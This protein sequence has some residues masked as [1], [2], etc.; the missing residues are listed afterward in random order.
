MAPE[1]D[2]LN[3]ESLVDAIARREQWGNLERERFRRVRTNI[4]AAASVKEAFVIPSPGRNL[5]LDRVVA[6]GSHPRWESVGQPDP[7]P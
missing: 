7:D 3:N 2:S 1:P 6:E 5:D 4:N